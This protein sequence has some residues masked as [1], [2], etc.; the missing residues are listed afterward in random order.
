[1]W[2]KLSCYCVEFDRSILIIWKDLKTVMLLCNVWSWPV[3][4]VQLCSWKLVLTVVG[5]G[6]HLQEHGSICIWHIFHRNVFYTYFTHKSM[7]FFTCITWACKTT[8]FWL[9]SGEF[10]FRLVLEEKGCKLFIS[11]VKCDFMWFKWSETNWEF[12]QK[13]V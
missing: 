11:R 9:K 13:Y 3:W 1:M 4:D 6:C 8:L 2:R 10:L 7:Y 12:W 5:H